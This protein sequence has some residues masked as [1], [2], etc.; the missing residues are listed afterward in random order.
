MSTNKEIKILY[1]D[2]PALY[3]ASDQASI[4]AQRQ[5]VRLTSIELGL[6]IAA[7]L[8]GAFT[9][10][11]TVLKTAL[12]FTSAVLLTAGICITVIE[13][14]VKPER[15]WYDGR[16]IAE[17]VKTM[18]WQYM[19]G[20]GQY[21]IDQGEKADEV[22]LSAIHSLLLERKIF[23]SRLGSQ[24][25]AGQQITDN[26]K[27]IR[28]LDFADRKK[29]YLSERIEDQRIWYSRK[30]ET[31]RHSA[32]RL[33]IATIIAQ[34]VAIIFAFTLGLLQ[35]SIIQLTGVFTTLA[36]AFMA[37]NQM[38]RNEELAQSY[39]LATQELIFI[40]EQAAQV[41]TEEELSSYVISSENA[42]SREHKMWLAKGSQSQ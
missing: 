28:K 18:A 27:L 12:A 38:K 40:Y 2:F 4:A 11:D 34:F 39:G 42:I 1:D 22:F 36:T 8:V 15:V 35:S 32:A 9:L 5:F 21:S 16:A 37:W 13:R 30:A 7:A 33:F 26:M 24:Y 19:T 41:K 20:S 29:I 10:T 31:N 25:Q 14:L 17:S 23:A 3:R 6:M